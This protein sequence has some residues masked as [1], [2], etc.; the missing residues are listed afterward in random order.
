MTPRA[1]LSW[2]LDWF[3][4]AAANEKKAM[5]QAV[6]GLWLAPQSDA[7]DGKNIAPPYETMTLVSTHKEE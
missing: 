1:L 4:E 7:K 5:V 6:Y 2:L 3:G